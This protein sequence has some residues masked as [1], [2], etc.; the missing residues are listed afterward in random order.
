M[1]TLHISSVTTHAEAGVCRVDYI[2]QR[3]R[4]ASEQTVRAIW[5]MEVHEV[6]KPIY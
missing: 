3:K 2:D 4:A 5:D 1:N 6:I